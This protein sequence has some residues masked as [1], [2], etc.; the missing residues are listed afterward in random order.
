MELNNLLKLATKEQSC[1]NL[2]V[3][4]GHPEFM[5]FEVFD[6]NPAYKE[7]NQA[8]DQAAAFKPPEMDPWKQQYD[9]YQQMPMGMQMQYMANPFMAPGSMGPGFG[10]MPGPMMGPM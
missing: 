8:V 6:T 9:P 10:P 3:I 2:K 7:I 5:G 1:L 4:K